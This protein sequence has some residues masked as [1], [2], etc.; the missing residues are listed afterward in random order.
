MRLGMRLE[1]DILIKTQDILIHHMGYKFNTATNCRLLKTLA[2]QLYR[3][4]NDCI[5]HTC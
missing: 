4:Q 2:I 3:L 1:T 5:T